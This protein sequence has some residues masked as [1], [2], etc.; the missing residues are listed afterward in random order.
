MKLIGMHQAVNITLGLPIIRTSPSH[1]T[2]FD[3]VGQN[4][5][6][7]NGMIEAIRIAAL[8]ANAKMANANSKSAE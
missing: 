5:T 1:G 2:A 3:I 8:L 4:R 7:P 6:D